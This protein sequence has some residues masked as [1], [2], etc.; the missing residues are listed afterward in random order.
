MPLAPLVAYLISYGMVV[1]FVLA[2]CVAAPALEGRRAWGLL[3]PAGILLILA[4]FKVRA[5]N[6]GLAALV[7]VAVLLGCSALGG[8]IG[9]KVEKAGYLLVVAIISASV[10]AFSVLAPEG[11]TAQVVEDEAL[12]SVL[13][14]SWPMAGFLELFP[15]LGMG[16]VT[17]TA[18]YF[19]AA[20]R[21]GL[22]VWRG[23]IAFGI[24]Y[25]VVA[26]CVLWAERALPA[27]PFL[28]F[29][30]LAAWPEARRVP[31]ED[32]A[33]AWGGIAVI[34]VALILA[35]MFR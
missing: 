16:D 4:L 19:V 6:V 15:V 34:A 30:A 28:G 2:T 24:A 26:I 3:L 32:R 17:I 23:L 14:I 5:D 33:Q 12:L 1:G 8:L 35:V 27:L 10:D 18:L 13:A 25:I 31:K 22:S 29:A 11:V 9:G 7:L 20:R 21:H